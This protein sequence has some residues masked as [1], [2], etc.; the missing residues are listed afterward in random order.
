MPHIPFL[1]RIVI[2]PLLLPVELTTRCTVV[3]SRVTLTAAQ[4]V[5]EGE[6]V[7]AFRSCSNLNNCYYRSDFTD[8]IPECCLHELRTAE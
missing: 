4:A 2:K 1:G 7:Y 8:T 6:G 3:N 5:N